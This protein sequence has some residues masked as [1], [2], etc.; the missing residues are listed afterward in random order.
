MVCGADTVPTGVLTV[1][2]DGKLT[3]G[4]V[5]VVVCGG[6]TDVISTVV[7][8]GMMVV[9]PCWVAVTSLGRVMTSVTAT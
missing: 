2:T 4:R 9:G 6:A 7:S 8:I 5:V 1:M 3:G